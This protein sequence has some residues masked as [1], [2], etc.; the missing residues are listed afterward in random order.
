MPLAV[1]CHLFAA[2]V[3]YGQL[4]APSSSSSSA[5]GEFV[6]PSLDFG[7][8]DDDGQKFVVWSFWINAPLTLLFILREWP[9]WARSTPPLSSS[10][11]SASSDISQE[12]GAKILVGRA[13]AGSVWSADAEEAG[14]GG[15]GPA[16][17]GP[18]GASIGGEESPSNKALMLSYRELER[19]LSTAGRTGATLFGTRHGRLRPGAAGR[20]RDGRGRE[21][22]LRGFEP[23]PVREKVLL[24]WTPLP[25]YD[26][27]VLYYN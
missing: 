23:L 2:R 4:E 27:I 18:S 25:K 15:A 6:V 5:A 16:G 11:S 9:R 26:S 10:P 19:D 3:F 21:L 8:Q 7:S 1:L 14:H 22:P 13:I 17:L 20:R 24:Q 12:G